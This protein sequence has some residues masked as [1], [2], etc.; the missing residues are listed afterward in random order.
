M[1]PV[2][3][4][5]SVT[6]KSND[7]V[8]S[9]RHLLPSHFDLLSAIEQEVE[10]EKFKHEYVEIPQQLVVSYREFHNNAPSFSD[11]LEILLEEALLA[12][13]FIYNGFTYEIETE[14]SKIF[15]EDRT[16]EVFIINSFC[17][18]KSYFY[19][20]ETKEVFKKS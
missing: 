1:K 13:G 4:Y 3:F 10:K 18:E 20:Y 16:K 12:K 17:T 11:A 19:F 15:S 5:Q 14:D 2:N 7:C 8:V 6:S 9:D